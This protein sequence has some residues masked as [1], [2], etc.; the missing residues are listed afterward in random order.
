MRYL[1]GM[2]TRADKQYFD[3]RFVTK[4]DLKKALRNHPTHVDFRRS[5]RE[6]LELQK[7]E[8]VE[9]ITKA[10]SE[11]IDRMYEKLDAFI[12]DIKDKRDV[13]ELHDEDHVT[14]NH[15]LEALEK[16]VGL[17]TP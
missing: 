7:P 9:A 4:K 11:K 6:E 8:W 2:L 3:R 10:V 13:Q 1:R 16:R 15:R 14:M 12:G 5:I 17:A